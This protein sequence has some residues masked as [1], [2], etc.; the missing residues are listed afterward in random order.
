MEQVRQARQVSA[1]APL[2]AWTALAGQVSRVT[3][4]A[5]RCFVCSYFGGKWLDWTC[6][7]FAKSG[8]RFR[9]KMPFT[10]ETK[11]GSKASS[12]TRGAGGGPFRA[13]CFGDSSTSKSK[14]GSTRARRGT[15]PRRTRDCSRRRRPS[16]G[17]SGPRPEGVRL[18]SVL[19]GRGASAGIARKSPASRAK[20][21]SQVEPSKGR[22]TVREDQKKPG[23]RRPVGSNCDPTTQFGGVCGA[24][25]KVSPK[26]TIQGASGQIG[27]Y[28]EG[29]GRTQTPLP[30]AEVHLAELAKKTRYKQQHST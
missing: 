26:E 23:K 30:D 7:G 10:C 15:S 8:S 1:A 13:P 17:S 25:G 28:F 21:F 12:S 18:T 4:G 29:V 16:T 19:L 11:A 20:G 22:G 2:R 24:P 9:G 27:E 3:A 6:R 14:N 5:C